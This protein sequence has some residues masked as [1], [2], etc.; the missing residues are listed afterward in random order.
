MIGLSASEILA[1]APALQRRLALL[2]PAA[3]GM[4]KRRFRNV[5]SLLSAA[6]NVTEASVARNRR[7]HK[8]SPP[9]AAL[10]AQ[11][12]DRYERARLSRFFGYASAQ[13]LEPERTGDAD[14]ERF[15]DH[16]AA[17]T[18]VERQREIVREFCLAWNRC[19]NSIEGW[20]PARLT[21]PD[22]RRAYALPVEAYPHSF[23][24]DVDAYL[25]HLAGEDLFSGT[26]RRPAS[27]AT[28]RDVRLRILQMA[29]ALVLSGR[30]P[31]SISTLA[32]LVTPEAA[33]T[34]LAFFWTRN[35]KRK[36]GQLHNFA[37]MV[38]AIACHWIKA[39][40]DQIEALQGIRRQVDPKS[41]GMTE[42]NRARLR[43][44]DDDINVERLINM[45]DAALRS[46]PKS[47]APSYAQAVRFQSA[48]A[49]AMLLVAPMRI[50]N[51]ASLQLGRHLLQRRPGGPRHIVFP[52]EEVKN[53]VPL[54]YFCRK[55]SMNCLMPISI[56]VGRCWRPTP[57]ASFFRRAKAA[58]RPPRN[59]RPRSSAQLNRKQGPTSTPTPFAT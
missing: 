54:A 57:T 23:G 10:L 22:R 9:W 37:R 8:L 36:T 33:K 25:T 11:V 16:L 32:D 21:V 7:R 30:E 2:T 35:G 45:P 18:L 20:P 41:S 24:V 26:A 58:Q 5:L 13:G 38:I 48:L 47:E 46:L 6:L 40:A 29:A 43:Q 39:P 28:L 17:N 59:W 3:A 42:R 51:L 12:P 34:A 1:D 14:V 53:G 52:S 44:F 19:A 50:K 4:T 56:A 31:H 55:A 15:A 49:V 27:P